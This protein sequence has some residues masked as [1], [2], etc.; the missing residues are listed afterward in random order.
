[1][2][3]E[4]VPNNEENKEEIENTEVEEKTQLDE[5]I[6]NEVDAVFEE[7]SEEE[8][9][10]PENEVD[11]AVREAEENLLGARTPEEAVVEDATNTADVAYATAGL[12]QM[13]VP[14]KKAPYVLITAIVLVIVAVVG[15]LAYLGITHSYEVSQLFSKDYWNNKY[16][17]QGYVNVSGR[18][19]GEIADQFGMTLDEFKEE[20]SL[21]ADM[22]ENTTE[23]AALYNIPLS[24]RAQMFSMTVEQ[25]K[26][27]YEL[28]DSV[29]ENTTWGEA[30]G[31]IP[32]RK[33]VGEDNV[34]EFKEEMG[35]GNSVTGETKWKKVRKKFNLKRLEERKEQE[36]QTTNGTGS[37]PGGNSS[38]GDGTAPTE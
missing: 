35:F 5:D 1:M 37:V 28:G 31:E 29:T 26:E 17:R 23:A 18:T 15:V 13:A 36:K 25:L 16:N 14:K 11:N 8:D 24:R 21:P 38:S 10:L 20:Y 3:E 34:E 27:E 22:K 4:N 30:E 12:D 32:L 9:H 7:P 6:E 19:I 2:S 33:Y